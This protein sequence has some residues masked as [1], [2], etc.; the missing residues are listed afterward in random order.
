MRSYLVRLAPAAPATVST[1][2]A[3]SVPAVAPTVLPTVQRLSA[4]L[5]A[6]LGEYAPAGS[7]L[8]D[9]GREFVRDVARRVE[10]SN[11]GALRTVVRNV[12]ASSRWSKRNTVR[13][14]SMSCSR[15]RRSSST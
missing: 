11:L 15:P 2:A 3:A 13:C 14:A 12:A 6:A 5:E 8:S 10:V 7:R 4:E 1:P 9:D